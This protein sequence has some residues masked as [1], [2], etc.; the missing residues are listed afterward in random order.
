VS[1]A[2]LETIE[3]PAEAPSAEE[4][5]RVAHLSD[6]RDTSGHTAL[7]GAAIV[8]IPAPERNLRAL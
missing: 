3:R 2:E 1:V 6:P 7:C 4:E 8:G 5:V